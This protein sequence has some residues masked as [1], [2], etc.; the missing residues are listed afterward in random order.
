MQPST[1]YVSIA[2][3]H[4]YDTCSFCKVGGG[5]YQST[6]HMMCPCGCVLP[7][8]QACLQNALRSSIHAVCPRCRLPWLH[9]LTM[10]TGQTR[11]TCSE[12]EGKKWSL[13][14]KILLTIGGLT[15]IGILIWFAVKYSISS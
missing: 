9:A 11:R 10:P 14:M 1:S 3:E 15:I 13:G 8:H 4:P 6:E 5:T 12:Q 7:V 2:I